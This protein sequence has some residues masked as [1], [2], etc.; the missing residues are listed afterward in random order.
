MIRAEGND[1]INLDRCQSPSR[2]RAHAKSEG[3]KAKT[4]PIPEE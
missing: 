4:D 1:N 2:I 3:L